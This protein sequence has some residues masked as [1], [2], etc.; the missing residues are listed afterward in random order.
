LISAWL[1]CFDR[2]VLAKDDGGSLSTVGPTTARQS[3]AVTFATTHWSLVLTA[4][5]ESPAAREVLEKLCR[6]YWRPLYAFV[7]QQGYKH[8]EAE[9]LTQSFFALLLERRD[10]DALRAEKGK[11]RSYL[12]VSLKHFLSDEKQ[13]GMALKRGKGQPLIPLEDLR[14]CA[15]ADFEPPDA[16]TAEWIYERR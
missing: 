1:L 6:T 16:Q 4:Q 2:S 7:R 12:L 15:Q 3:G 13:R 11:L 10:F 9:D 5:G 8:E 14:T